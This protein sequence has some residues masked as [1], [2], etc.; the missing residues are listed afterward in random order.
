MSNKLDW[1]KTNAV[2]NGEDWL[3]YEV[4]LEACPNWGGTTCFSRSELNYE[5]DDPV[6][7]VVAL[8][9]WCD[10][11]ESQPSEDYLDTSVFELPLLSD[12]SSR[13]DKRVLLRSADM[14][15]VDFW[16]VM[17]I[18][19]TY[20]GTKMQ[21]EVEARKA[22]PN[23]DAGKRYARVFYKTFYQEV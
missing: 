17:G 6:K 2:W 1:T 12:R 11:G 15:V 3:F 13:L 20:Y 14:I 19:S 5:G 18:S 16:Y 21:A 7:A 10:H 22:F 4:P 8:R 9:Y 23:E